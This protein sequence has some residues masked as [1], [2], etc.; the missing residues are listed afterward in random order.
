MQKKLD[1]ATIIE[2][3]RFSQIY[4]NNQ[5]YISVEL[6]TQDTLVMETTEYIKALQPL[7]CSRFVGFIVVV[8]AVVSAG[9]VVVVV[10][11]HDKTI[12]LCR[13]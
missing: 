2:C 5:I 4:T 6:N 3:S 13:S 9:V 8:V 7:H 10:G 12:K 1:R 11:A